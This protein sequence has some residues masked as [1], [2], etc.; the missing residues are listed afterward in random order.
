MDDCIEPGFVEKIKKNWTKDTTQLRYNYYY[1][2]DK[3]DQPL[4][5]FQCGKIHKRDCYRWKYPIHEV[6]EFIGEKE[7]SKDLPDL[8]VKHRPDCSKSRGFYLDLLEEYVK[9]NPEDTRN[10][11]LLA[12]EYKNRGDW[13]KCIEVAHRYLRIKN[14]NYK[15]ERGQLMAFMTKSYRLLNYYEEAE[16]WG[17][18]TLEE[19]GN[20]RTPYVELMIVYYEQKKYEEAIHYGLEALKIKQRNNHITED[21]SC[22]DG[23]IYDYLSISYYYLEDYDNAIKYIDLDIKQNPH[24]ERLKENKKLFIKRRDKKK[25]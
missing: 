18:K 6:L 7:I 9:N 15:Q 24:I 25:Q 14:A 1:S 8:I 20:C 17:Q 19:V 21:I 4:I 16:L 3:Q 11:F 5:K 23:T 2:L 12:R 22:W 13:A 10:T